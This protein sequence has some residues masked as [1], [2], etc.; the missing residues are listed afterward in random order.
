MKLTLK[1]NNLSRNKTN[2]NLRNTMIKMN[3]E[4]PYKLSRNIINN[5]NSPR[6]YLT[7]SKNSEN[8]N[9]IH[10]I[11]KFAILTKE[12]SIDDTSKY[13]MS[14]YMYSS[15]NI[16]TPNSTRFEEF[17]TKTKKNFFKKQIKEVSNIIN[18]SKKKNL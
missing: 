9:L 13:L 7:N 12:F 4:D 18:K 2:E 1:K 16:N 14:N 8:N 10:S 17:M 11:E 3:S 6:Q 5:F 15:P